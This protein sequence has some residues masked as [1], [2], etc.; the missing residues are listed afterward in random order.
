MIWGNVLIL[1]A[2]EQALQ[3]VAIGAF[4]YSEIQ[5]RYSYSSVLNNNSRDLWIFFFRYY[6]ERARN[7]HRDAI[8]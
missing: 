3:S 8:R 7:N 5:R 4:E 2:L 1:I 6:H